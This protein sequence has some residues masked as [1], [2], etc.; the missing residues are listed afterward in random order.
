M[1]VD[2]K[3]MQELIDHFDKIGETK[4]P[5]KA[6]RKAG[7]HVLQVEKQVAQTKHIKYSRNS[8]NSGR[9]QLKRFPER[10]RKKQ[11][12]VEIGLKEKN[13]GSRWDDIKGLYFNHYGFYHNGWKKKNTRTSRLKGQTKNK[14]IAGSRWMDV[15]FEK[16]AKKAYEILE[17]EMMEGLK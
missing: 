4:T 13:D 10:I 2:V 8:A 16:S 12:F 1:S 11:S 15:A 5:R 7:D 9:N 3:G 6:L 14:Y 17:K